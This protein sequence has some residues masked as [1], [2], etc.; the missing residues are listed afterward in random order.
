MNFDNG[1][2]FD[3]GFVQHMSAFVPNIEYIYAGLNRLKNFT[4]KKNQFKMYYPKI[5][6]LLKN[7]LGF[8]LGCILWAAYISQLDEKP[9]LN[10]L[11]FGGEYSEK[12]TLSEVDFIMD[13]IE[14]L[15]KDVKYYTGQDFTI[16]ENSINI[17][18]AYREFLIANKGFVETKTTKDIKLPTNLKT[19][20][21]KD[22]EEI[23][24]G[25]EKVIDNGKL[26]ELFPLAQKVL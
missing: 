10:N 25:I 23:L 3:P 4:L 8:Y 1:A 16:D 18:N 22:L 15:K 26:Y 9:I 12:E 14:Q 21:E 20:S 5:Q 24:S 13:Y 7:Y 19:P 11:C 17:L 2:Q 6:S